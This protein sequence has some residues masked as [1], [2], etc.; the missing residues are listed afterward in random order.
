MGIVLTEEGLGS[1]A[2]T[3]PFGQLL[4]ASIG[5]PGHLRGEALH[6]VLLLLQQAFRDKQRHHYIF[7]SRLFKPG[8]QQFLDIF[9]HRAA[10]GTYNHTAPHR[11]VIYQLGF[12]YHIGVP[13]GKIHLH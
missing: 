7:M 1:G 9:P 13:F 10:I 8:I 6:M 2:D 4:S 3:E 12:F 5:N 11:G